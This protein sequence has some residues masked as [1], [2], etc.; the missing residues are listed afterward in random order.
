[1]LV[2]TPRAADIRILR[3]DEVPGLIYS[4]S[5]LDGPNHGNFEH[6]VPVEG[7]LLGILEVNNMAK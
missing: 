2:T 1:M 7:C 3:G 6:T 5:S 4:C